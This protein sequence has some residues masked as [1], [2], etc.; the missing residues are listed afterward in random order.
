MEQKRDKSFKENT[1]IYRY[2]K[3]VAAFSISAVALMP[4]SNTIAQTVF[5][6]VGFAGATICALS[7]DGEVI[8]DVRNAGMSENETPPGL[9]TAV[10]VAVGR[11][12]VCAI[13]NDGNIDCWGSN[14]NG[15][16][17]HP[18]GQAPYESV[19]ISDTHACAINNEGAIDCWGLDSNNR[20]DA[21]EGSFV[22]LSLGPQQGCAV[23]IL[24]D[25][26]CWG[27]ND[28]GTNDVPADLPDAV[29][30]ASSFATSCALTANGEVNCW[31]RNLVLP[32]GNFVDIQL[33]SR[34][35]TLG[36]ETEVC[37]LTGQG[38][39]SCIRNTYSN[40]G[41]SAD[42]IDVPASAGIQA[43][44]LRNIFSLSGG[45]VCVVNAEGEVDCAGASFPDVF[46]FEE[47]MSVPQVTELRAEVYSNTTV[48]LFWN[49]E[50]AAFNIAGHEI[51]RNGELFAFTPNLSSFIVDD[52]IAGEA[53]TF[54]IQQVS[55]EGARGAP[56]ASIVVATGSGNT[57]N[58]GNGDTPTPGGYQPPV[59]DFEPTNLEVMVYGSTAI[60]LFWDRAAPFV[61][62][63]YEIRRN[64]EFVGFTTGTSYFEDLRVPNEVYRYDVI[65]VNPNE[66][67]N[68][69]GISSITVGLGTA[70]GGV[71]L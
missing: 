46:A 69:L 31:G 34:G 3:L 19:S 10:E 9:S 32:R 39:L 13:L 4:F 16:L 35:N 57:G 65:A 49:S 26:L 40:A 70:G 38:E 1:M 44:S 24:D 14:A 50:N 42:L 30:V 15:L 18:T 54:A 7:D 63:G 17:D 5:T 27:S 68:I 33:T 43:F 11:N 36:G 60:E 8:C 59:R 37:G 41:F 66:P 22:S 55:N 21:P 71:C 62:T 64:G 48:E 67:T 2:I 47:P 51:I 53:T 23:D 61:T 52:L 45:G 29:L 6:D 12:S 28:Q 20:L 58:T 56:S 25:V